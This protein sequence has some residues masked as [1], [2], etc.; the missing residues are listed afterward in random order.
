MRTTTSD[1]SPRFADHESGLWSALVDTAESS[2]FAFAERCTAARFLELMEQH[3][4]AAAA[5]GSHHAADEAW[6]SA[7]VAFWGPFSGVLEAE[8]PET[9]ARELLTSFMGLGPDDAVQESQLRDAIGEFANMV[10]GT[11]LTRT[12][13][14]RRFD[15]GPPRVRRSPRPWSVG[16]SD[17]TAESRQDEREG[18]LVGCLNDHPI[19]VAVRFAP[20]AP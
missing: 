2:F 17:R 13:C 9:L 10:C 16:L 15:L 3:A 4:S 18:V 19:R 6:L 14:E 5:A 20:E 11:W 1:P 7:A 8:V 12:C